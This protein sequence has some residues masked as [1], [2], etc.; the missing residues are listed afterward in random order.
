MP[1]LIRL[2]API[3]TA[4]NNSTKQAKMRLNNRFSVRTAELLLQPYYGKTIHK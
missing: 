1:C 3:G 4:H 2:N